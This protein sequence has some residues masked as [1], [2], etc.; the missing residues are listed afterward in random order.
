MDKR[1]VSI[2]APPF[3]TVKSSLFSISQNMDKIFEPK[4]LSDAQK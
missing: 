1:D 4:T 2:G 3:M